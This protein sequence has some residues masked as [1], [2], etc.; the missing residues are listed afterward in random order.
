MEI[1]SKLI[2]VTT[3]SPSPEQAEQG[4]LNEFFPLPSLY[5][6][7]P[8]YTRMDLPL[9]YNLNL[10][11]CRSHKDRWRELWPDARIVHFTGGAKPTGEVCVGCVCSDALNKWA[12]E[13]QEMMEMYHWD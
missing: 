3:S 1:Y 9:K 13:Y 12:Y 4:I 11:A 10:E 7:R 2:E 8:A 5:D 6:T